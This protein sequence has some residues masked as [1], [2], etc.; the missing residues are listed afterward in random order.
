MNLNYLLNKL[1]VYSKTAF[2]T[3]ERSYS[4]KQVYNYIISMT[5][6]IRLKGV[7]EQQK[8]LVISDNDESAVIFIVAASI[9]NI[10]I[11][12]PYNLQ[13]LVFSEWNNLIQSANPD[14]IIYLK[15]EENYI[16]I[17]RA[18]TTKI[19]KVHLS[20]LPNV[21]NITVPINID[22][23]KYIRNFLIFFTS[24]TTAKPKAISLSE[25]L[26]CRR[27]LNVSEKLKFR[28][29]SNIFM[30]GLMNNTTG[31][32]FSL[33]SLIHGAT[34]F[35]PYERNFKNWPKQV[36]EW[37]ITHIMLRPMALKEFIE[38][39]KK[40]HVDLSC[41][42]VIAYGAAALPKK[43]LEEARKL[44][45]CEWIQGY[46][47]S[48]TF[49]PFCWLTEEDHKSKL[50]EKYVY[51]IGKPDNTLQ[52]ALY[53]NQGDKTNIGEIIV[54]GDT[55]MEGYY[56]TLTGTVTP[57]EGWFHTGDYAE[58][59]PEGYFILKGRIN[60]SV[61]TKDGHRIYSEEI[62][63]IV[64]NIPGVNDAI[65]L[66]FQPANM[67]E[68]NPVICIFG[69]FFE[70]NIEDIR[71]IIFNSI[72]EQVSIEKWPEYIFLCKNPF[73]INQNDKIVRNQVVAQ[74]NSVELIKFNDI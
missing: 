56:N 6:F 26:I 58:L 34:L 41:M 28:S 17:L 47:L 38:G 19:L 16:H 40:S 44:I 57:V 12:M 59:S 54:K 32:I 25:D 55:I 43:I 51:C 61:L 18:I 42:Q 11:I 20:E 37:K 23:N 21:K 24:G 66:N 3:Q 1:I 9:L 49:G 14:W 50:Y 30:S 70:K 52:V 46:G 69:N 10:K 7:R 60:S 27:F 63:N 5:N 62:E 35:F 48:E 15:K 4:Y 29:D 71:E 64:K 31:I 13:N 65:F 74:I 73:P 36:S 8:V 53:F 67:I 2:V 39:A 45:S 68:C 72:K 22:P 33:G